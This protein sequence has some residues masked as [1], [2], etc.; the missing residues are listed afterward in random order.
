MSPEKAEVTDASDPDQVAKARK[1][2]KYKDEDYSDDLRKVLRTEEGRRVFWRL[3]EWC[4]VY[5]STWAPGQEIYFKAA[6]RDVGLK[7]ITDME[8]ADPRLYAEML[9]EA[10]KKK[11]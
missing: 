4:G 6:K 3:L 7:I 5:R 8:S 2:E 11:Q 10:A 1:K 9:L